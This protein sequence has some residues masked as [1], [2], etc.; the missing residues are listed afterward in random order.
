MGSQGQVEGS[1]AA[2]SA[3]DDCDGFGHRRDGE[4]VW[5]NKRMTGKNEN[6]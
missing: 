2:D 1:A 4:Y 3:E 5:V 6:L